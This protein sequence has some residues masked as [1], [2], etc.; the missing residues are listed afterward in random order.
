MIMKSNSE[1]SAERGEFTVTLSPGDRLELRLLADTIRKII[2]REFAEDE[3]PIRFYERELRRGVEVLER[4]L[5][6]LP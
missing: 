3:D 1:L 2:A 4:F 6:P 5:S